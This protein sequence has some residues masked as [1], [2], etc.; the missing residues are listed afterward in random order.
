MY[1]FVWS[2]LL[3][4]KVDCWVLLSDFLINDAPPFLLG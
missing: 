1:A 4:G 3:A 2:V